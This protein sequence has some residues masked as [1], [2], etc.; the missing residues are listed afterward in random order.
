M[1]IIKA[2]HSCFLTDVKITKEVVKIEDSYKN[3][4]YVDASDKEAFESFK[5]WFKQVFM[6]GVAQTVS[7][8]S[9][10]IKPIEE[11]ISGMFITKFLNLDK[12]KPETI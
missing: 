3:P 5:Q 2:F 11:G 9:Y 8:F 7:L 10:E 12:D 6:K 4:Y 1:E